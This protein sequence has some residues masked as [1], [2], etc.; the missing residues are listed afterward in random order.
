MT[1]EERNELL[2]EIL[3]NCEYCKYR[4]YCPEEECPF[5]RIEQIVI[6]HSY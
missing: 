5:Y 4:T 1:D 3:S 2:D 6:K